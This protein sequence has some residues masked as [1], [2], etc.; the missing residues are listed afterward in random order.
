MDEGTEAG[1]SATAVVT[2]PEASRY[3]EKA[4][5]GSSAWRTS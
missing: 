4:F 2:R 3:V 1:I 5:S